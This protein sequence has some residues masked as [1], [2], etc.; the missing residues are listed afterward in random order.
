M[1][2]LVGYDGSQNSDAALE[3]LQRAGLPRTVD[4][5][6]LTVAD[7]IIPPPLTD[8]EDAFPKHVPESVRLAQQRAERKLRD[9][10]SMA[11]AA[12]E[13]L[14][15]M[16][17]H[18]QV[19][20]EALADSPAW[21][22]IRKAEE[23]EADLITVSAHGHSV[24]GARLILGSVSQRVL[25]EAQC[26]V[27]IARGR[28]RDANSSLRIL[29]GIDGSPNSIAALES[30]CAREWPSGTQLRLLAVMDTL[31][32]VTTGT[33]EPDANDEGDEENWGRLREMFEPLVQIARAAGLDAAL[34]IHKGNPKEELV[35][36]AENW[37]ADSIF[38]G[39]KGV[40]G[41]ERLLLGSVS[42]VV[43]AHAKCSVEIVRSKAVNQP[44]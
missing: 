10:E 39:A 11:K 16:F 14:K 6:V 25:Y 20:H 44:N 40:R 15:T 43:S 42:S 33:T 41:I 17:P 9:A 34:K 35:D 36:E 37:E 24:L 7:V 12:S 22:I 4:A 2:L 23:I 27:R 32:A 21:A 29:V 5:L 13:R 30:V 31:M 1:K 3:D 28:Q 8:E 19:K 38:M 26:S 18:W